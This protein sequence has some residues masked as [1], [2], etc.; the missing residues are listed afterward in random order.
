VL[1][2]RP[3]RFFTCCSLQLAR[4]EGMWPNLSANKV[5]N[6]EGGMF[7]QTSERPCGND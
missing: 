1:R 6:A 4:A 7:A 3:D 2:F 5:G